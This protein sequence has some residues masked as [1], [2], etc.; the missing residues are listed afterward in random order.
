MFSAA[1]ELFWTPRQPK[2]SNTTRE[3]YV[4]RHCTFANRVT[5]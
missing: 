1:Q 3:K 2:D 4:V 5:P